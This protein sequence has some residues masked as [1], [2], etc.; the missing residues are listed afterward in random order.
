M[1]NRRKTIMDITEIIRRWQSGQSIRAIKTETGYDRETIGKYIGI[2]ISRGISKEI[3]LTTEQI[4][5]ILSS[6]LTVSTHKAEKTSILEKHTEEFR[7]LVTDKKNPLKAKSA[8]EVLS[9]R[10]EFNNLV[11]Y[12]TFKRF[13]KTYGISKDTK[14]ATC[15]IEIPPASQIQVDYAKVGYL[16]DKAK[17]K[18]RTVYAF[19]G[20]LGNSRHKFVEFVYSQNQ[21]S[22]VE[23]HVKMFN[24]FGGVTESIR[25]DNLKSGVIKPDLYDPK[26]NRSYRDMAEYYGVFIDTCRVATPTDK[27]IVERDVQTIRE[28]FRKMIVRNPSITFFELNKG[29]LN[30]IENIYGLRKHGT[31][32]LKPYESFLTEEKPVLLPLPAEAFEAA[33]WKEAKVHPDHYIQVNSKAYSIDHAYVGK[34]VWVKATGKI[35]YVYY[36]DKL[37]KQHLI[38][39]GYRQTDLNDFPENMRHAMD[40]GMPMYLRKKAKQISPEFGQLIDKILSPHAYINMRKAQSLICIAEKHPPELVTMASISVQNDYRHIHPKLFKSILEKIE[41]EIKE[42]ESAITISE[43]T[44]GFIRE[45][46]YFISNN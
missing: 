34:T 45:M 37:I 6:E 38:P 33:F 11:S 43:N 16:L 3:K 18:R 42:N 10:H 40:T 46:D 27:P 39:K 4:R 28:E 31:T 20:T 35:V 25:I 12:T 41:I 21:Q 32:Q 23:S 2:A 24:Y 44:Q 26:L 1:A 19:I 15:R 30:W 5:E 22:F 14:P 17:N 7:Q 29:I 13:A 9:E 8:F 36:N